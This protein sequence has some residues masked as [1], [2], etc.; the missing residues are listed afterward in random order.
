MISHPYH[1][2][3]GTITEIKWRGSIRSSRKCR[4]PNK[5]QIIL[6][7]S[8]RKPPNSNLDNILLNDVHE[9][10]NL[11]SMW[12]TV[13]AHTEK[14]L[15]PKV[16]AKNLR[17]IDLRVKNKAGKRRR[18]VPVSRNASLSFLHHYH[19]RIFNYLES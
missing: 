15:F 1:H 19:L 9:K 10:R 7:R 12:Q 3:G 5:Y 17:V 8:P 4:P 11:Q 14:P 16:E 18:D 6:E 2:P 13:Q